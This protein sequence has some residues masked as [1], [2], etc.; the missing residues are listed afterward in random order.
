[1]KAWSDKPKENSS[2][3]L[4]L[5]ICCTMKALR[6]VPLLLLTPRFLKAADT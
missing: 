2:V 3:C 1:M 6:L 5:P 4:Y